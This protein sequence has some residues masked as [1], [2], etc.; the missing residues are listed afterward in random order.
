MLTIGLTGGIGSGKSL[1]ASFFQAL[2]AKIIDADEIAKALT[3][4]PQPAYFQILNRFGEAILEIDRQINRRKLREIIFTNPTEKCWLENLLHPLINKQIQEQLED[5]FPYC[6]IVIPLLIE[7]NAYDLVDRILVVD[8]PV[9]AQL[10]RIMKRDHINQEI[11]YKIIAAQAT[12]EERLMAA[13]EIILNTKGLN[14]LKKQVFSLHLKY[15][16]M[17]PTGF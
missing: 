14:E 9:E 5:N 15:S 6:I 13:D 1:A 10:N 3:V 11:A 17:K 16:Q 7:T 4:Y 2:G 12:R 8:A